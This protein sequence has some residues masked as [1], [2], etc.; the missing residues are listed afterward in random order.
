M[1]SYDAAGLFDVEAGLPSNFDASWSKR[2]QA[3]VEALQQRTSSGELGFLKLPE[4]NLG[5][6]MTWAEGRQAEGWTDQIVVGIGGSS[7]GTRAVLEAMG[8][9]WI[10][11]IRTHFAENLDPVSLEATLRRVD[12]AST[13]LVVVTKSGTT[14]E[15]MSQLWILYDAMV[16]QLGQVQADR[17]VIAITDPERGALRALARERDWE[18][19]A[20]PPNVG[21]RFSVLTAVSLVPLALAGYDVEALLRGAALIVRQGTRDL[22]GLAHISAQHIALYEKGFGQMVMMAYADR[23]GGLVDWFRQLWAESLGKARDR[24]GQLVNVGITPIKAMGAVDQHSQVQL[25]MEGPNDKQ[26]LFVETASHPVGFQ[27]PESPAM[28]E[29]L[30][31]LQGRGIDEILRAEARGTRAALSRAQRPTA[32]WRLESTGA[33]AVGGFLMSWMAITALAGELLNIDAFDQPGVE[34]GKIIAHGLLG[35]PKH[36]Q[37]LDDLE[38]TPSESHFSRWPAD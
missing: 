16:R 23:L 30:R 11:A 36:G 24:S 5:Q 4:Q 31:H 14:I 10:P 1:L 15:T 25:Y 13:L 38:S 27:V 17:Q 18:T 3:A 35:H 37:F 2:C 29:G 21:G 8:P 7:L 22:V 26:L 34:L 6:L 20:V 32:L 12:L 9:A 28:P 19:H 33:P